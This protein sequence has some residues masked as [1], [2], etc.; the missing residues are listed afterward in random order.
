[1]PWRRSRE[2]HLWEPPGAGVTPGASS[3]PSF[4]TGLTLNYVFT[5][6]LSANLALF[7]VHRGNQ[8]GGGVSSSGSSSTEDTIDIGPSLNY[9]IN[10]SLS[11]NVG[12]HYMEVESGSSFGSYSRN[13]YF[14]GL[15]LNF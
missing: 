4:R 8:S 7:Y 13:S 15:N 12:Y 5:R 1:M 14:A 9:L 3:R 6:R 10:R 2:P 11:A